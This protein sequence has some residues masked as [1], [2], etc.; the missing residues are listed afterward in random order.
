MLEPFVKSPT[1]RKENLKTLPDIFF[2]K[3]VKRVGRQKILIY[4]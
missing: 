3:P 2:L 1:S 4:P